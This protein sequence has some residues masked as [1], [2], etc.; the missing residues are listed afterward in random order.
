MALRPDISYIPCDTSPR[1]KTGDK[2]TFAQF[3]EGDLSSETRDDTASG[4][5]SSD[6][7]TLAPLII[8]E[9]MGMMSSGNESD[10]EPMYTDMLEG[11]CDGSQSNPIINRRKTCYKICDYIKLVQA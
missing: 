1:G 3:E 11:I 7:S 8:E 4:N 6:D 10:D 5:K 2:I 9:G